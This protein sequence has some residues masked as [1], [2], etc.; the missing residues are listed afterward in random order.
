MEAWVTLA[1]LA[2]YL[3]AASLF[4]T[5]L[6]LAY[7]PSAAAARGRRPRALA[8]GSALLLASGAGGYWM[9]QT[10]LM[11]GDPAAASDPEL[12]RSVLLESAVGYAI[13]ARFGAAL[14]AAAATL[15][16]RPGRPLWLVLAS[17]GG[18]A[19][20]SFAWTGHGAADEGGAGLIH[21]AADLV[22]L[23]GAG[24][25]L[26]AL[27]AFALLLR[28]PGSLTRDEASD[29]HDA[30]RRFACV[31]SAAVAAIVAS[32]LV[33]SWF[34]VGPNGLPSFLQTTYGWLLCGKLALFAAMLAL[35][36]RNRFAHTPSLAEG[37]D[38]RDSLPALHALRTSVGVEMAL[39]VLVLAA[40]SWLGITPPPSAG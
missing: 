26:G 5:P 11:A 38:R 12:L 18:V 9:V 35:A 37:L 32:G 15:V 25:W 21:L 30:L 31:G 2:Q 19:L 3:A 23:L 34:L 8:I 40:V 13:L 10:G 24:V 33:N 20:A 22:H 17:S 4:G 1:R 28:V 29:L 16:L 39:G 7:A 36:A 6:F 14:T 27:A